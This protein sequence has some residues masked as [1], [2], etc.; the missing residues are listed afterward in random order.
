MT[1]TAFTQPLKVLFKHCDPA[2]VVFYP[3]Y[4]EIINDMVEAFFDHVGFPFEEILKDGGVPTVQVETTFHAPSRHGDHLTL[5]LELT[6]IGT[7][8][9]GI[10]V[11]AEGSDARRFSAALTL[12][13]I[14]AAHRPKSWSDQMRQAFSPYLRS[15]Q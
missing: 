1:N 11:I 14:N 13:H 5:S 6:R 9:L 2:G 8:S 10:S 4:F 15:A 7:A 12:V 3:R